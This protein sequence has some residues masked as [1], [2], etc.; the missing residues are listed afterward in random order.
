MRFSA[1]HFLF[2]CGSAL[3]LGVLV[4]GCSSRPDNPTT[5][6]SVHLVLPTNVNSSGS[7]SRSQLGS[8]SLAAS[9][10]LQVIIINVS[11]PD[12]NT[13]FYQ[14]DGDC[15]CLSGAIAGAPGSVALDVPMGKGRL[16]QVLAATQDTATRGMRIYYKSARVDL[17]AETQD[18][19]LSLSAQGGISGKQTNLVGRYLRSNG[20]APTG[21]LVSKFQPPGEPAMVISRSAIAAGW[22]SLFAVDGANFSYVV[23]ETGEELSLYSAINNFSSSYSGASYLVRLSIPEHYYTYQAGQP[24]YSDQAP[25]SFLVAGFFG[26]GAASSGKQICYPAASELPLWFTS[27]SA[28]TNVQWTASTSGGTSDVKLTAN[29]GVSGGCAGT[30]MQDHLKLSVDQLQSDNQGRQALGIGGVFQLQPYGYQNVPIK[31]SHDSTNNQLSLSWIYLPGVSSAISGVDVLVSRSGSGYFGGENNL[32]CRALLSQG[33]NVNESTLGT[34][35]VINNVSTA[36]LQNM[37]VVVCPFV[38]G[39]ASGKVYLSALAGLVRNLNPWSAPAKLDLLLLANSDSGSHAFEGKSVLGTKSYR[40]AQSLFTNSVLGLRIAPVLQQQSSSSGEYRGIAASDIESIE[41]L[42]ASTLTVLGNPTLSATIPSYPWNDSTQT[43]VY[44]LS[45]FGASSTIVLRYKLTPTFFQSLGLPGINDPST[46]T[47]TSGPISLVPSGTCNLSSAVSLG[48]KKLSGA[49][50][51]D[52]SLGNFMAEF[53]STDPSTPGSDQSAVYRLAYSSPAGCTDLDVPITSITFS[54]PTSS[55]NCFNASD[56]IGRANATEFLISPHD[57]TGQDC[58]LYGGAG[59]IGSMSISTLSSQSGGM[60][61]SLAKSFGTADVIKHSTLP[62]TE[63]TTLLTVSNQIQNNRLQV[64]GV[65][66]SGSMTIK[67]LGARLNSDNQITGTGQEASGAVWSAPAA[68][69]YF[70]PNTLNLSGASI[71]LV[72]AATPGVLNSYANLQ[73]Q[74]GS[75]SGDLSVTARNLHPDVIDMADYLAPGGGRALATETIGNPP[76]ALFLSPSNSSLVGRVPIDVTPGGLSLTVGAKLFVQTSSVY[77]GTNNR[78]IVSATKNQIMAVAVDYNNNVTSSALSAS[79]PSSSTITALKV[80]S[81]DNNTSWLAARLDQPSSTTTYAIYPL[82]TFSGSISSGSW[83]PSSWTVSAASSTVTSGSNIDFISC[84]DHNSYSDNSILWDVRKVGTGNLA[85]S[86]IKVLSSGGT[87]SIT[88]S[89][90]TVSS[91]IA[92]TS[93]YDLAS[94][95]FDGATFANF[96]LASTKVPTTTAPILQYVANIGSTTMITNAQA[97]NAT[98]LIGS[99]ISVRALAATDFSS[100]QGYALV[101]SD[102]STNFIY[103]LPLSLSTLSTALPAGT[104]PSVIGSLPFNSS[105]PIRGLRLHSDPSSPTPVSAFALFGR[106]QYYWGVFR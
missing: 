103:Y 40:F 82:P 59:G 65:S 25:Q 63:L 98:A 91:S 71:S 7:A 101:A 42:N 54:N 50:F 93:D 22:M 48:L 74:E 68:T 104:S 52:V 45:S 27:S 21:T 80:I 4:G 18:V 16:I 24:V 56:I 37:N 1:K 90:Q 88:V 69:G 86:Y 58:T 85:V 72:S 12:M 26:P 28:T 36:N 9:E 34:S 75:A 47:Y 53:F 106:G 13:V 89:P 11:A 64:S 92:L 99:S 76:R 95:L 100:H 102:L 31:W 2:I 77:D 44:S 60:D 83:S 17:T 32:D 15:H 38:Y 10:V 3:A 5:N 19:S 14:W 23:D 33:Y 87:A 39:A 51:A 30:I 84:G 29:S 78:V 70:V 61:L 73:V 41:V 97:F 96:V 6:A 8:Q 105:R 62:S 35:S 57:W 79:V 43:S 46:V 55:T 49:S 20:T 81:A 67:L 94:C 66:L